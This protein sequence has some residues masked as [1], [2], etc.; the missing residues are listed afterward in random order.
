MWS[1]A[2]HVGERSEDRAR[3]LRWIAVRIDVVTQQ[4]QGV[5]WLG[6]GDACHGGAGVIDPGA[7]FADITGNRQ[8][9][10]GRRIVGRVRPRDRRSPLAVRQIGNDLAVVERESHAQ[11][12]REDESK[13]EAGSPAHGPTRRYVGRASVRVK[14]S[15]PSSCA[16]SMRIPRDLRPQTS[17]LI[18]RMFEL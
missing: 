16:G 1:R 11:A 9:K 13:G 10:L 18:R 12:G 14:V 5:E 15:V 4:Q 2:E 8:M 6:S 7:R 3:Q 17:R